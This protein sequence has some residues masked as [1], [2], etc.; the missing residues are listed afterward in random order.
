MNSGVNFLVSVHVGKDEDLRSRPAAAELL[1][2]GVFSKLVM[3][4]ERPGET[5]GI[6]DLKEHFY[7][8]D[9]E[10]S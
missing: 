9:P 5:A 2:S 4:G 8:N 7:A 1:S 6:Y 10:P 3:L